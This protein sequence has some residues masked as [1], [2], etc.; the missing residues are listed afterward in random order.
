MTL[1]LIPNNHVTNSFGSFTQDPVK[2]GY[3]TQ[4]PGGRKS[5]IFHL[6]LNLAKQ[7]RINS[8][9]CIKLCQTWTI[10]VCGLIS[11]QDKFMSHKQFNRYCK[12]YSN[13]CSTSDEKACGF[14]I[15][16]YIFCEVGQTCWL[17]LI[18]DYGYIDDKACI[19]IPGLAEIPQSLLLCLASSSR[20]YLHSLTQYSYSVKTF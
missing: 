6:K 4:D 14:K 3:F 1:P 19:L 2:H 12:K 16:G 15:E 7:Y 18:L 10:S 11:V 13:T 20:L 17:S 8:S 9:V 5:W